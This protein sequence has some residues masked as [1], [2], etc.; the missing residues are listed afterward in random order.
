MTVNQ[1]AEKQ[2]ISSQAAI[3]STALLLLTVVCQDAKVHAEYDTV[4]QTVSN[5]PINSMD[6][7]ILKTSV[8]HP[9]QLVAA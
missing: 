9:K 7:V 2:D 8:H 5:F 4:I 1:Q 3:I 6:T